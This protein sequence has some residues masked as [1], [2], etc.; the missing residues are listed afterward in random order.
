MLLFLESVSRT[1]RFII[2]KFAI[3]YIIYHTIQISLK[4]SFNK[5][6]N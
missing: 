5:I 1:M 3:T 6:Y 2:V 4:N